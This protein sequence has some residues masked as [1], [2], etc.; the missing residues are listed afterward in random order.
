MCLTIKEAK[1]IIKARDEAGVHVMVGYMRRYSPAFL[2]MVQEVRKLEKINYAR[3]RDIKGTKTLLT[4]HISQV[5][6]FNDRPLGVKK[7]STKSIVREAIGD[8]P[9]NLTVSVKYSPPTICK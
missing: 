9:K 1:D 7:K 8:V 2:Q 6:Q 3:I 5:Y 4:S